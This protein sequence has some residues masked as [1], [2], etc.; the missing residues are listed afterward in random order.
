ME[1]EQRTLPI[2]LKEARKKRNIS[3]DHVAQVIG[4]HPVTVSKYERGLQDPKT[5]ALIELAR[6]YHVSV[7]WLLTEHEDIVHHNPDH[8][9]A[10]TRV[11][12]S[13]PSLFVRVIDGTISQEAI[14][15]IDE[16]IDFILERD[17]RRRTKNHK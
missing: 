6:L 14:D 7:D 3:Q 8:R 16:Y 10:G 12:I 17:R 13:K 15:D 4:V 9:E 11:V 2:R 5:T 1:N